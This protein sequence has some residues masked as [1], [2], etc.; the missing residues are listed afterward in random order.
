[1][2]QQLMGAVLGSGSPSEG[3]AEQLDRLYNQTCDL[4]L[5]RL[6]ASAYVDGIGKSDAEVE[7]FYKANSARFMNDET[8]KVDYLLS[9][10]QNLGRTSRSPSRM[11]RITTTSIRI[12]SSVPSAVRWRIP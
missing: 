8:V 12:C 1:M 2:R 9:M 7:Q 4:R 3:E 5:I 11:P 6:A 10:P